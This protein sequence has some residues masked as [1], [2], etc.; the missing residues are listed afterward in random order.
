MYMFLSGAGGRY[1]AHT[2]QL[3][4]TTITVRPK[5]TTTAAT[6]AAEGATTTTTNVRP[7]A[8]STPVR[9]GTG[10]VQIRPQTAAPATPGQV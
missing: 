4:A 10:A 8:P 5:T 6:T 2:V 3:P 9:V 1:G 7:I